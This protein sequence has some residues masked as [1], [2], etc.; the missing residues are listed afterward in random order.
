MAPTVHQHPLWLVDTTLRDGEQAP[1]VAFS[2]A[3]KLAIARRLADAG[4]QELEVGTPAMG[5][6]EIA[7]IR[8]IVGLRLPCRLTAWCRASRPDIDLAAACGV[9]AVHFSLPVS[10]THLRAMKKSRAWV[11]QQ[12]AELTDYARSRFPFVSIGA[13][14]A[15]RSAPGFLARCADRAA[16]GGRPPSPG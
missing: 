13:Q 10:A 2:Q 3:E 11:L 16:S 1:G 14:D 7:A 15:S 6:E 12:I 4:L 8:A 9:D 5:D